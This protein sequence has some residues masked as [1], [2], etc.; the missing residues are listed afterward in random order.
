MIARGWVLL[1]IRCLVFLVHNDKPQFLERQEH[2]RTGT[3]DD[4]VGIFGELF[5]PYLHA[6][7]IGIFRM[8]DAQPVAEHPLQA[9][10]HLNGEGYL[11]QEIKHLFLALQCLL[12]EMDVY[13]CLTTAGDTVQ[14]GDGAFHHR[15]QD[16]VIGSLLGTV[17]WLDK[18]GMVVATMIEPS[19]FYLISLQHTTFLQQLKGGG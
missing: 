18:F 11:G 4:V 2:R 1:L 5:L 9:L 3:E 19:D 16:A 15:H 14:Q 12:N 17:Q 7:G 13:F 6:L 10:H 8:I